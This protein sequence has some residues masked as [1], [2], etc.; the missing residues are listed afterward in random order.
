MC[1]N[2]I[3]PLEE[4]TA[5]LRKHGKDTGGISITGVSGPLASAVETVLDAVMKGRAIPAAPLQERRDCPECAGL[6][7]VMVNMDESD[8]CP[9]CVSVNGA[10]PAWPPLAADGVEPAAHAKLSPIVA[11]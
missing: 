2:K 11:G 1:Q 5:I 4:A 6:H 9:Q 3:L 8:T 10:R 7:L